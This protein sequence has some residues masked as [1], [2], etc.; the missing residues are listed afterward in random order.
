MIP[1]G[2]VTYIGSEC[3]AWSI[4]LQIQ[5]NVNARLMQLTHI[6]LDGILVVCTRVCGTHSIDTKPAI[7]IHGK[8]DGIDIPVLDGLHA[9]S[10]RRTSK[11]P[12]TLHTRIF[13]AG[14]IYTQQTY[15]LSAAVDQ[16]IANYPDRQSR[17]R[18][19]RRIHGN[20]GVVAARHP[21]AADGQ[22]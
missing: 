10:I 11:E 9:S 22:P 4:P 5:H 12:P 13:T 1:I 16:L 2:H 17:S 18:R 3:R 19:R 20:D 8:P 6:I 15:G 14:N 7:L 21:T